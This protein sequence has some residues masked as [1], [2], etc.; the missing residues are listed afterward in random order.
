[1]ERTCQSAEYDIC[2]V[3]YHQK[4]LCA[5]QNHFC[6]RVNAEDRG[7]QSDASDIRTETEQICQA[8]LRE[9]GNHP[10]CQRFPDGF[11]SNPGRQTPHV[12]LSLPPMFA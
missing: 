10:T 5:H 1:M 12:A 6:L 9:R 3:P 4:V 7:F 11:C 8:E 2:F